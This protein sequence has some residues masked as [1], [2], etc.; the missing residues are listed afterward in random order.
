VH[1][2]SAGC[3]HVLSPCDNYPCLNNATCVS[4]SSNYTCHCLHE[5]YGSHC[6]FGQYHSQLVMFITVSTTVPSLLTT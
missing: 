6:Q 4:W 1:N 2:Y 3:V 5:F